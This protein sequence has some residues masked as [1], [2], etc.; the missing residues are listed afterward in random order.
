MVLGTELFGYVMHSDDKYLRGISSR[1]LFKEFMVGLW[2]NSA[3]ILF[4]VYEYTV[5]LHDR[6][7]VSGLWQSYLRKGH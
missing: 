5:S 1:T 4:E 7:F 6:E 2:Y 3:D